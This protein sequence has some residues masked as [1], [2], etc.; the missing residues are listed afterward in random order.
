[1]LSDGEMVLKSFAIGSYGCLDLLELNYSTGAINLIAHLEADF[2]RHIAYIAT[3]NRT[4]NTTGKS[5]RGKPIDQL[6]EHYVL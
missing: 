1:M 4:V 5:G 3:H 6:M 2:P